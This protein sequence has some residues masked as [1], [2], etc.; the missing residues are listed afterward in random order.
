[1]RRERGT[2]ARDERERRARG[3]EVEVGKEQDVWDGRLCF[4]VSSKEFKETTLPAFF[5]PY[6]LTPERHSHPLHLH[7]P[8]H[9]ER[10]TRHARKPTHARMPTAHCTRI[11]GGGVDVPLC[12]RCCHVSCY[13]AEKRYGQRVLVPDASGI[14]CSNSAYFFPMETRWKGGGGGSASSES[15]DASTRVELR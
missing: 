5:R 11:P 7:P 14:C 13:N 2:R 9:G 15:Y 6:F 3:V 8:T 1:M 10:T 4:F 12:D